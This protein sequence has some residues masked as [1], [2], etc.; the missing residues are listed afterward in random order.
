MLMQAAMLQSLGSILEN[1]RSQFPRLYFVS[2]EE[3]IEALASA[4]NA[5]RL[6]P[7]T[8]RC[9]PGIMDVLFDL[10]NSH[11]QTVATRWSSAVNCKSLIFLCLEAFCIWVCR[12]VRESMSE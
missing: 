5:R 2:D 12:S 1:T 10:S 8:R 7:L 3:L 11:P 6:L 4:Q 9:F